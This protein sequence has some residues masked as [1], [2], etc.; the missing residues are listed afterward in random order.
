VTSPSTSSAIVSGWAGSTNLGDELLGLALA[1]KLTDRG[2]A[3]IV[4][5]TNPALTTSRLGVE[6]IAHSNW[7]AVAKSIRRADSLI[8]GGG[9]LIQDATSQLNLPYHLARPRLAGLV[10]TPFSAIGLGAGPVTSRAAKWM[11][12]RVLNRARQVG[13]RDEGSAELL[14]SLGIDTPVVAADLALSLPLPAPGA[15]DRIIVA[16]RPPVPGGMRPVASRT[17]ELDDAWV[18]AAAQALDRA[19]SQ[20]GLAVHFVPM[21]TDRDDA[22]HRQVA[23]RMTSVVTHARPTIDTVLDELASGRVVVAMRYHGAIGALMGATPAVLVGYAPKVNSLAAEVGTGFQL[24]AD[25]LD[26]IGD[27]AGAVGTVLEAGDDVAAGRDRL[28]NREQ[29]NDRILDDLLEASR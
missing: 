20:T 3:P 2:V 4:I 8:M 11:T 10:G 21:Q 14:R 12:R 5:S 29:L 7:P 6:A 25:G 16:L 13:V 28:R 15:R 17:H 26:G 1:R 9:G 18:G 27:V 19:A 24:V 22:V 23:D